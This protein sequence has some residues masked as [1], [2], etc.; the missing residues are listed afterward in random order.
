MDEKICFVIQPFN[1]IYDK[2]YE[3]IYNPAIRATGLIP[4]R[5]DKD[6][7]ARI[8]IEQIEK[9]IE[10]AAIC[11]ADISIDNPNV[12]Y[13]L[14]YAFAS[15]KDV[16]MVCDKQRKDFPFDVRQKSII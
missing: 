6:P 11:F 8:I 2:R 15:G 9:K 5:V 1:E 4:Y 16:V 13:E 14:G 12:W 7:S 10:D 3:D